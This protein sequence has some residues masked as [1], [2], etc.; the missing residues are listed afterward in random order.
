MREAS[1]IARYFPKG[2]IVT[3]EPNAIKE[4]ASNDPRMGTV[5]S[6]SGGIPPIVQAVKNP[7]PTFLVV[8]AVHIDGT[9]VPMKGICLIRSSGRLFST[10]LSCRGQGI[11]KQSGTISSWHKPTVGQNLVVHCHATTLQQSVQSYHCRLYFSLFQ[12]F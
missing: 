8:N 7:S 11:R 2:R 5:K 4:A 10:S 12:P 1:N 3:N 9:E 6:R